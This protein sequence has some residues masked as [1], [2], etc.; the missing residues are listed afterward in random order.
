[1]LDG[2][3][4]GLDVRNVERRRAIEGLGRVG[5]GL[6]RRA[7]ELQAGHLAEAAEEHALERTLGG[8]EQA[9]QAVD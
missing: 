4:Q 1:M 8:R 6:E 5:E 3:Q 9:V 7:R 2:R